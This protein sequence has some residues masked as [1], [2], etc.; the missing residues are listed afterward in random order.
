[1]GHWPSLIVVVQG[2][3]LSTV[4]WSMTHRTIRKNLKNTSKASYPEAG[5]VVEPLVEMLEGLIL[6]CQSFFR[7]PIHYLITWNISRKQLIPGKQHQK[8]IDRENMKDILGFSNFYFSF[9][10]KKSNWFQLTDKEKGHDMVLQSGS[11]TDIQ[12]LSIIV[13]LYVCFRD[14]KRPK[15][16]SYWCLI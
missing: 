14:V 1:M 9:I 2:G 12:K 16:P 11:L 7:C 8:P 3:L 5:F 13:C 4:Q 10:K 6:L 15:N